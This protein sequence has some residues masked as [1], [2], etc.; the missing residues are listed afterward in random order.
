MWEHRDVQWHARRSAGGGTY[1]CVGICDERHSPRSQDTDAINLP[2][3]LE[4]ARD[5]LLDII[6]DVDA[7]HVQ[8]AILARERPHTAHVISVVAELI[9]A[10]AVNVGVEQV[11]QR[12]QTMQ[13]LAL[14]ALVADAAREEQAEIGPRDLIRPRVSAVLGDVAAALGGVLG[15]VLVFAVAAGPLVVPDV[16]DGAGLRGRFGLDGRWVNLRPGRTTLAADDLFGLLHGDG[17]V[18]FLLWF[19]GLLVGGG[20]CEG[21]FVG[22]GLLVHDWSRGGLY[23]CWSIDDCRVR[24]CERMKISLARKGKLEKCDGRRILFDD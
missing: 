16:E 22:G 6:R 23:G 3:L 12:R 20:C 5:N 18:A 24:H 19:L 10:K 2:P 9:T 11:V 17:A 1:S 13:I 14:V 21:V 7:A 8:R 15:Q 4:M